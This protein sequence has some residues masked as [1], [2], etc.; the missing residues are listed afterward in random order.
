MIIRLI[1]SER[2]MECLHSEYHK[3]TD[4]KICMGIDI[5]MGILNEQHLVFARESEKDELIKNLKANIKE[6]DQLLVQKNK[7]TLELE[8]ALYKACE[9]LKEMSCACDICI[10]KNDDYKCQKGIEMKPDGSFDCDHAEWWREALL[11]EVSENDT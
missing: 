9:G 6:M 8:L 5:A 10:F 4:E 1:D 11:K 7:K 3:Q 2:L